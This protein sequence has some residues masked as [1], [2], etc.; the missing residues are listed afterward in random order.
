MELTD[1]EK[2]IIRGICKHF[3]KCMSHPEITREY[4]DYCSIYR[5]DCDCQCFIKKAN[6]TK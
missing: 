1:N 5:E 2:S 4:F 6:S 3:S